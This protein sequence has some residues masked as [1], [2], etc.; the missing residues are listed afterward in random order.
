MADHPTPRYVPQPKVSIRRNTIRRI[1]M[2]YNI[3]NNPDTTCENDRYI[4][5]IRWYQ[6][7]FGRRGR[8]QTTILYVRDDE[9]AQ[10]WSEHLQDLKTM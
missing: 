2:G 1:L 6:S 3:H 9:E 10:Y 7:S 8:M 5:Y 4:T